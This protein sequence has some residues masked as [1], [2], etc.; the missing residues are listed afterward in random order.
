MHCLRYHHRPGPTAAEAATARTSA[1]PAV[2]KT[3]TAAAVST[4]TTAQTAAAAATGNLNIERAGGGG[5]SGN[6]FC[7]KI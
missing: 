4:A 1:P 5:H 2:A 3:T 6:K 7:L